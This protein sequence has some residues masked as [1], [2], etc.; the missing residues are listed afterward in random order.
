MFIWVRHT[1]DWADEEAFR[2][3]LDPEL[4]PLVE[5]WDATFSMPYHRFRHQLR[6]IA[7][8]NLAGVE[9]ARCAP[10]EEIP[11]GALVLPVDDDDWFAPDTARAAAAAHADA[12]GDGVRWP[13]AFLEVAIDIRHTLSRVG[14]GLLPGVGPKWICTTN[15]YALVKRPGRRR[16]LESHVAASRAL[17][18]GEIELAPVER[19]LS[20]MNRSLASQTSLRRHATPVDRAS[21]LRKHRRYRRL[22]EHVDP[23][24]AR[25]HAARMRELMRRLEVVG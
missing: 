15:N 20:L 6:Q 14:R 11:A 1:L 5:L 9:G 18:S 16:L 24:W 7:S 10:W 12:G 21:L 22:Y 19:P 13:S 17:A 2:A 8:D 3:Q 25:P 23:E 4:R